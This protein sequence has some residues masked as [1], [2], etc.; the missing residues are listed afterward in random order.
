MSS[1]DGMGMD[2]GSDDMFRSHNQKLARA[3]WYL[4]AAVFVFACILS[5][6]GAFETWSR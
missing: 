6:L 3:Y 5:F 1:M 4:V 2:M